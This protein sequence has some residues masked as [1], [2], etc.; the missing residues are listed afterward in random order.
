MKLF[1]L[2][3]LGYNKFE[4]TVRTYIN[5]LLDDYNTRNSS[6]FGQL[7]NVLGS[8]VQNV[9][10]YIED[11]LT[12]QNKYTAQRKRSIYNLA[13]I[14][15]YEPNFGSACSMILNI[16]F[17]S[18]NQ[19]KLDII[20][21]N[22]T[23]LSC[24]QNNCNYSIILDN[25]SV[26]MSL[27]KDNSTKSLKVVEGTFETQSFISYG[28]E[29]YTQ[30]V[31]FSGDVDKN[32]IKV[33]IN[34]IEWNRV[35][36]F[37]DMNPE[38]NQYLVKT[39]LK[40]GIDLVFG[41]GQFGKSLVDGDVIKIEYLLHSGSE[42]NITANDNCEFSFK[43]TL[44]DIS[45]EEIDGNEV[46]NLVVYDAAG[47]STGT[48]SDDIETIRNMIGMNSRSLV[49]AASKNY[50][51]FLNRFSFVGYNKTWADSGSL[52]INSLILKNYQANLDNGSDYFNL[53]ENDF[54]LSDTQKQS[55]YDSIEQTN[56][57]IAGSVFNIFDPELV[58]YS[59]YL[60]VKLKDTNCDT[61]IIETNIRNLIG[62]FFANISNDIYIPKSDISHLLKSNIDEID[63]VNVYFISK[64]N[65]DALINKYYTNKIYTY[66]F[67]KSTYNIKEEIVYLY[68]GENPNL[69]LDSHGNIQLDS[70][71]QVPVLIGGWS[72]L[73]DN[74]S[75]VTVTDP[76]NII[77]E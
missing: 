12:E 61:S 43:D 13:S 56:Q 64:L 31:S 19:Q 77:F 25:E 16:F 66:N 18:N 55:I 2:I 72:F 27:E 4:E 8:V 48:D 47:V 14:S 67:D 65:E 59:M 3:Q 36:S 49:L 23:T 22:H 69:G 46:F 15:G 71:D 11:A 9:F 52:V 57:S 24:S 58:K 29:L 28:G 32:Y 76:L 68:D 74:N 33:Y 60:Y 26:I 50:K 62:N 35:D 30:N 42:G 53:K 45:G 70:V 44:T 75:T 34:N 51:Q 1:S 7:I 41:N 40:K 38:S 54:I 10:S 63:G 6:I 37:Y 17:K 21:P 39:S 73:N 5:K 20:I